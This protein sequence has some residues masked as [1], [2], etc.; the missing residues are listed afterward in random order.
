MRKKIAYF[1]IILC[2]AVLLNGC[3]KEEQ[4]NLYTDVTSS[5]VKIAVMVPGSPTDGGWCQQGA[6]AGQYLKD[7]YGYEVKIIEI[8]NAES[9]KH[10][11][12]NLAADGYHIIFGHGGQYTTPFSE[13][14]Q[15]YPNTYFV[16]IG[17]NH[18]TENMF[19]ICIDEE[20]TTYI[21]GV[22]AGMMTKSNK[23]GITLTGD[24]PSYTKTANG[25]ALGAKSVN[26]DVEVMLTIL[27]SSDTNEGYEAT[28]NQIITGAD[29]IFSNSNEA[30]SGAL[31]A[32]VESKDVYAFPCL[33]NWFSYGPQK[34][35]ASYMCDYSKTYETA[36]NK[37]LNNTLGEP[38]ILFS[39]LA[40]GS[41]YLLWNE[42]LK[43][44]LPREVIDAAEK[45][46]SD[47]IEGKINI[48][49]EYEADQY[50]IFN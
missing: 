48:P 23:L 36:T 5:N 49:N 2:M 21:A 20:E 50:I 37:I 7:R 16:T 17:G 42:P 26:P 38:G 39:G 9:M 8:T 46:Y 32:V 24:F 44:E 12:E 18:V 35:I 27:N 34:F 15:D 25:F 1:F 29:M 4:T 33:G 22:I 3:N 6:E 14:A 41:T 19:P 43:K 47:I 45:A 13:I 10:E 31:K 40:D 28:M 30:Q 11:A